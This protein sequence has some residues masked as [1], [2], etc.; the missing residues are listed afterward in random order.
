MERMKTIKEQVYEK[1]KSD[2]LNGIYKPGE[3]IQELV[4]AKKLNVSRSPVREALKELIGEGLLV[5]VP[6]K[7]IT[8]KKLSAKEI[9]DIFDF[10]NITEKYAI[11]K[12]IENIDERIIK[13]LE[14]IKSEFI[15]LYQDND[16]HR[17]CKVD[18][19]FHNYLIK[20][21]GNILLHQVVGNVMALIEQFRVISLS[22]NR[23][24][25]ESIDEHVTIID[26]ILKKNKEAACTICSRHLDLAKEEIISYLNSKKIS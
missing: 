26:N 13:K 23:R 10:R 12:T 7:S 11:E 15:K 5:S 8:V 2:V 1:L 22:S 3:R 4:I 20:S 17:Y 18:S 14:S 6:N 25:E 21:S 19:E 24:F 9:K 16:L